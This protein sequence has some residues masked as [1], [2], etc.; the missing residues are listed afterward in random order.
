MAETEEAI[1]L[2]KEAITKSNY[3]ERFIILLHALTPASDLK[4][5]KIL[6]KNSDIIQNYSFM[7]Y[8][9]YV[10]KKIDEPKLHKHLKKQIYLRPKIYLYQALFELSNGKKEKAKRLLAESLHPY[11][12]DFVE[13]QLAKAILRNI[14]E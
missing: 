3:D 12:I 9:D 6:T 11:T 1:K 13:Y 10:Q 14:K 8:K 5:N 7:R 4:R 2:L